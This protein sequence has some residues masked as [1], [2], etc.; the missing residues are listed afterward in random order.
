[1][2]PDNITTHAA[3]F[4]DQEKLGEFLIEM[5]AEEMEKNNKTAADNGIPELNIE[6]ELFAA[7]DFY[8]SSVELMDCCLLAK[9]QQEIVGAC[10]VNPFTSSLQFIGVK[11]GYQRLGIG[12][13]LLALGKKVLSKRGCT[14][15][16]I[17]LPDNYKDEKT[18]SFFVKN[19][20]N[21]VSSSTL[22]AGKIF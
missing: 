18:L 16:K 21:V 22:L 4:D 5:F 6:D 9:D 15:L 19:K 12:S 2:I 8:F 3:Q 17:E 14:H 1:M 7:D 10:C 13:R 11:P 20:I